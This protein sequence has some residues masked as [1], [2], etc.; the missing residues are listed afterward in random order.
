LAQS[1]DHVPPRAMFRGRRR[2][3][4]LE[5]ASCKNCNEGTGRADLVAALLSRVAPDA[6]DEEEEAELK[7]LLSGVSNKRARALRGDASRCPGQ[8]GGS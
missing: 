7:K 1:V 6:R 4:G 5:F 8:G 3:K 2:P